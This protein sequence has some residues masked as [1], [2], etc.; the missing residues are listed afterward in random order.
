[1][2]LKKKIKSK[3]KATIRI[4]NKVQKKNKIKSLR[5]PRRRRKRL[6][7]RKTLQQKQLLRKSTKKVGKK[8]MAN[9]VI[10]RIKKLSQI[11]RK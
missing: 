2:V 5:K 6:R 1:M 10:M 8:K 9:G 11:G 4:V 7:K 3:S